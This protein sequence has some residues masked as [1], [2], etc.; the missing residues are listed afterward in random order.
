MAFRVNHMNKKTGVTYVYEAVSRWDKEKKQSVN[1]QV[2]I[3][4]LDP[5]TGEF[6]PSKRLNPSS[7]S[8]GI[9]ADT[10]TSTIMGP[11]LILDS[12]GMELDLKRI[13]RNAFPR[14]YNKIL[15]LAWYCMLSHNPLSHFES[16]SKNHRNP[17]KEPLA[18][19]QIEQ[20]LQSLD[21]GSRRSFLSQWANHAKEKEY[22]CHEINSIASYAQVSS[23]I[24]KDGKSSGLSLHKPIS[25]IILTGRQSGL[26]VQYQLIGNNSDSWIRAVDMQRIHSVFKKG[27][28][29]VELVDGL[30]NRHRHFLLPVSIHSKWVQDAIGTSQYKLQGKREYRKI[31]KELF[32]TQTNLYY[33]GDDRRR[34]YLH[35]YYNQHFVE[36]QTQEIHDLMEICR[37]ELESGARQEAHQHLYDWFFIVRTTKVRGR[38][39]VLREEVVDT[40]CTKFSG[41]K[42][43]LTNNVKDPVEAWRISNDTISMEHHYNDLLNLIDNKNLKPGG[44]D[45][46][47]KR[48]FIQFIALILSSALHKK[49][50]ESHLSQKFTPRELMNE[51]ELLSDVGYGNTPVRTMTTLSELQKEI[52][53]ALNITSPL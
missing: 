20:V 1:K 39:I 29:S 41:F 34:C 7:F 17:L 38:K 14:N 11:Y 48:L 36:E 26:P 16:W 35:V 53:A 27:R 3:G 46:L 8:F 49:I 43:I 28:E 37:K 9:P 18:V 47:E 31:G 50:S 4:K 25:Q 52:L 22:M 19:I 10:F 30:L 40:Y 33:W 45:S 2:C 23:S 5:V 44:S 42:A 13:I 12:I 24:K 15:A 32:F 6:I 51:M 21:E